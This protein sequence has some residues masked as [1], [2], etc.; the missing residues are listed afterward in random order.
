MDGRQLG[1]S[2]D[3]PCMATASRTRRDS[4]I[5]DKESLFGPKLCER[6]QGRMTARH[7]VASITPS[8]RAEHSLGQDMR[9][10]HTGS[11]S[12]KQAHLEPFPG[13]KADTVRGAGVC[14]GA[15]PGQVRRRAAVARPTSTA[16]ASASTNMSVAIRVH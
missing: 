11:R 10:L 13:V 16:S 3:D 2:T 12:R 7:G 9:P 15:S 1:R 4:P 5:A 6:H 14:A 8:Q